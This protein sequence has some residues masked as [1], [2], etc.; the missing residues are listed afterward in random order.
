MEKTE[1]LKADQSYLM[2]INELAALLHK[3]HVTIRSDINRRPLSLPPR[4]KLPGSRKILFKRSVVME[5]LESHS[6]K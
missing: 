4:V 1:N 3:S 5:W 6:E 2:T